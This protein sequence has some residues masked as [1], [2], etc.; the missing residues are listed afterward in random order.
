MGKTESLK[1]NDRVIELEVAMQ[2]KDLLIDKHLK[3]IRLLKEKNSDDK[4]AHNLVS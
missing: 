1:M 4:K 2:Q 3:H